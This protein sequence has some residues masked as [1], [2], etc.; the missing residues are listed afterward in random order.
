MN[1]ALEPVE[2]HKEG[3]AT[4]CAVPA[5]TFLKPV[6]SRAEVMLKNITARPI[7]IKKGVKVAVIEAANAVP[8][9]LAPK[10]IGG[11][12]EAVSKSA[13]GSINTKNPKTHSSG[14]EGKPKAEVDQTPVSAEQIEVLLTKIN[15]GE[16]TKEWTDEQ[17]ENTRALLVKYSFLFAMDSMDLGKTDL[18]SITLNSQIIPLLKFSTDKFLLNSMRKYESTSKRCLISEQ[19]D[20]PTVHGL[21]QLC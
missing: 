16:G 10:E 11:G 7:T 12:M 21:V 19:L 20:V 5:Y 1:V 4:F 14:P 6:S 15:F 17:R 13:Q 9:M 2:Q 3:E 18:V 8:Q